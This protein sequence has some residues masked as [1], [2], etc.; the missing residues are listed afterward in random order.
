[1]LETDALTRASSRGTAQELLTQHPEFDIIL[2]PATGIVTA[3]VRRDKPEVLTIGSADLMSDGT[4]LLEL[5][6]LLTKR[7]CFF[8]LSSNTIAG[9]V[10]FSDL[11]KSLMKI[12]FFVLFEAVERYLWPLVPPV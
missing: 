7:D 3:Y 12:P 6:Q 4:S 10:H 8:V 1:M 2:L 11:N 5:P 9:F